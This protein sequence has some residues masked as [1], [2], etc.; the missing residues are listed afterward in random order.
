[1]SDDE[2]DDSKKEYPLSD[3]WV[4]YGGYDI[5]RS[6]LKIVALVV[7]S[8]GE[9]AKKEL[10]LYCWKRKGLEWKVELATQDTKKW[11]WEKIAIK[12]N[13]L[14]QEYNIV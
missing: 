5:H 13:V 2:I 14:K 12:A 10:R 11:N 7:C 6:N 1:M 3:Y 9:G 8:R 4:V